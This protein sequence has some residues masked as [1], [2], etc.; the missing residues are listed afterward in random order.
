MRLEFTQFGNDDTLTVDSDNINSLNTDKIHT[1]IASLEA[2]LVGTR[3]VEVFAQRQGRVSLVTDDGTVVWTGVCLD[4]ESS[5]KSATT[6]LQAAGP[7]KLLEEDLPDS[8]PVE[9][10]SIALGDAIEE[11]LTAHTRFTDVRVTKQDPETVAVDETLQQA[12]T[13]TEFENVV[14][15]PDT[16]PFVIEN[17]QLK[18]A[19]TCFTQEGENPDSGSGSG[20]GGIISAYSGGTAATFTGFSGN[21]TYNFT[22]QYDIPGDRVSLRARILSE[23]APSPRVDVYLDSTQIGSIPSGDFSQLTWDVDL[24]QN[25]RQGSGYTGGTL[26][27]GTHS[28][29]FVADGS[30]SGILG[31]DVVAPYDNKFNYSFDNDNG[32]GGGYLDG[33]ELY[34]DA[35]TLTFDE[36]QTAFSIDSLTSE[37]TI[38]DVSGAQEIELSNNGGGNFQSAAN[39]DTFTED[40]DT[41][42][43]TA[44]HRLTLSRYGTRTGATPLTGHLGQTV[45]SYRLAAD[46]NDLT[47]IDELRLSRNNFENLK[48]LSNYGSY[49]FTIEHGGGP[50]ADLPIHAFE[51]GAKTRPLPATAETRVEETVRAATAQYGNAVELQGALRDDDTRP[52]ATVTD[53]DAIAQDGRQIKLT[54]RDPTITTDAGAQ[55]RASALLTRILEEQ[56]LRGEVEVPA[57]FATP[58]FAR[59]V[60]F[61][62]EAARELT[63]EE[64]RTR[65][66]GESLTTTLNFVPRQGLSERLTQLQRNLRDAGSQV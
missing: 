3:A 44:I 48:T 50:I 38:D 41:V 9:F 64:T 6:R 32:G 40:F 65:L 58:G 53:S 57:T 27:S 63:L 19:Q 21:T 55:F 52:T 11:Y 15:I 62:E 10:S 2:T 49:V 59:P 61:L 36:T 29:N 5:R 24:A 7:E 39:T 22:T 54:L 34:P 42:G 28:V 25:P 1:G 56:Q 18:L 66:S 30:G 14:D 37:L 16:D 4:V 23:I 12:D 8:A 31:I 45:D 60:G 13:N 33:P 20:A 35:A 17:G 47:V 46:I 43:R 26:S 51:R